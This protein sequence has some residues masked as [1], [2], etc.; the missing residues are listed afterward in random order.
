[1]RNSTIAAALTLGLLTAA[2]SPALRPQANTPIATPSDPST[3]RIQFR[4]MLP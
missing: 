1:M 2:F 4:E 3:H